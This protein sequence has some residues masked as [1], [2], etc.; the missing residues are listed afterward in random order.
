MTNSTMIRNA[1]GLRG[2]ALASI[3]AVAELSVASRQADAATGL[4]LTVSTARGKTRPQPIAMN[5]G[6]VIEVRGLFASVPA[7][8]KFM[9]SE[10][11]ET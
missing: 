9:K 1:L 8:R 5:R 11:A 6:T 10:R 7:R 4:S 2:E 3:G